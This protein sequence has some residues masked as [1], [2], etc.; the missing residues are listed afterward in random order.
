[1]GR[2]GPLDASV[3]HIPRWRLQDVIAHLG[4]VHRWA[5]EILESRTYTGRR[6][7]AGQE[8]GD[9]LI[10]WFEEGATRL[11][12][13]LSGADP[14]D[15]CGNFSP[16]SPQTVGFWRRRQ[17]HETTMHRWDA[18]AAVG[19]I[20]PI[21]TDLAGDGIDELWTTFTRTR[22]KQ[23][24][25]GPIR[26]AAT[27]IASSWVIAPTETPGRVD[28]AD[29]SLPVAATASGPAT[30]LL[31]ALWKRLPLDHPEITIEG[32]GQVARDFVAGPI[33]P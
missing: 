7:R 32:N 24:L 13:V 27:D 4:G 29:P 30:E 31:L 19:D 17:A 15:P 23:V 26:I 10:E 1:M 33:S 20:H 8:Q 12:A 11:T 16:G 3:P 25:A 14:E 28:V 21:S 18:E 5:A 9:A 6:H 2:R 22:G